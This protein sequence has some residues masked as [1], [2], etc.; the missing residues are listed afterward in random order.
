MVQSRTCSTNLVIEE[1]QYG[2]D[3]PQVGIQSKEEGQTGFGVGI[4]ERSQQQASR[5]SPHR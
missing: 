2:H 4:G 3:Y 1:G 5:I